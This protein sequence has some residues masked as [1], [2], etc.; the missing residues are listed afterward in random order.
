[1]T[2]TH[3]SIT[4]WAVDVYERVKVSQFQVG[5]WP[6]SSGGRLFWSCCSLQMIIFSSDPIG[7]EKKMAVDG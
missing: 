3:L 5:V 7:H 4:L 1:M 6:D 2:L